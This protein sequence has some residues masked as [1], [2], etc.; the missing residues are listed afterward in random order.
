ML[1]FAHLGHLSFY[2]RANLF[3]L[4]I[5]RE[6]TKYQVIRTLTVTAQVQILST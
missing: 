1:D 4:S 2:D 5:H 3:Q 6:S